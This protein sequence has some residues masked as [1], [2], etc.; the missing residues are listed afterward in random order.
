MS[1][2]VLKLAPR[3]RV[4]INGAVIENGDKRARLAITVAMFHSRR[5]P[6]TAS[7]SHSVNSRS[8]SSV[9]TVAPSGPAGSP[10]GDYTNRP[11]RC[12]SA[13]A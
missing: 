12:P 13:I 7:S 4:L 6:S 9:S 5:V 10:A 11:T 1:G 8:R 2:L 3:E